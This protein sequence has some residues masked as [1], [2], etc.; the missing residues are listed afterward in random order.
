MTA[1]EG[2][3]STSVHSPLAARLRAAVTGAHADAVRAGEVAERAGM[4]L[5]ST[6]I[7]LIELQRRITTIADQLDDGGEHPATP[8]PI[9]APPVIAGVSILKPSAGPGP[10]RDSLVSDAFDLLPRPSIR[11][12]GWP[13]PG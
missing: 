7:E 5:S 12:D 1:G 6:V 10:P 9:T 2:E 11:A 4:R 8:G 3:R 13:A